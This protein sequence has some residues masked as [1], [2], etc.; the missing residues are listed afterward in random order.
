MPV[1]HQRSI[2]AQVRVALG[3][4]A[5][6]MML[7]SVG[8]LVLA[9]RAA[10]QA[11]DVYLDHLQPMLRLM[12]VSE[13]YSVDITISFRMVRAGRM[14]SEEGLLRLR[15][16]EAKARQSWAAFRAKRAVTPAIQATEAEL[17]RLQVIGN[18]LAVMLPDGRSKALGIFGDNQ[19][20]PEV[21]NCS[22]ILE[23]LRTEE[24]RRAEATIRALELS[25]RRTILSGLLLMLVSLL[26]ALGLGQGFAAHLRQGVDSLVTHL[27]SVADG[28]LEPVP[29]APGGSELVSA[30][31]EL[32]RTVAHLRDLMTELQAQKALERAILDGTHAVI[33]GLDLEGRV[34]RWNRGA[35]LVLGYRAEEVM[36]QA[37]PAL[38]R[39]PEELE[40]LAREVSE[41][42]GRIV[43]PGIEALQA[44][45]SIPGFATECHYRVKDG[46]LVPVLLTISQVRSPDGE[47][48]GTMG[49]ALDLR[50]VHRLK[51]AL[52]DS[53][54][55]YQRLAE[56]LPG[57]VYQTQVWPDG[58]RT[59]PFISP[60]FQALLGVAPLA[61]EQDPDF[62]VRW[63]LP[64]E[65]PEF[66]RRQRE[67][68]ESLGPLTWE[69]RMA[70]ERPGEVKW[71][72]TRSNPTAQP[73]G[74][75]L[76]DGILEDITE[77]KRSEE[78]LR[79]S[80]SR[81]QEASRAKSSFL[82]SMS[83][84]L[85]TPLSAILGYARLM[86]RDPLR[87]EED[88][89]QLDHVLRAG[90]HL[91]ALINDVLSLSKIEA[92]RMEVRLAPFD[93]TALAREV[94]SLFRLTALAKGLA[95]EVETSGLPP[96]V[97]GDA[98]KLRQVLVNLLGNALKFTTQ[99]SV[100][101]RMSWH[102]DV[103][104]A[105]IEDTGPGIPVEEQEH[106]FGAFNQAPLGQSV[107]GTGLGLHISQALVALMLGE[108]GVESA[109]GRGSRFFCTIPLPEPEVPVALASQGR[110]V[111]LA[112]GEAAPHVLVVDDRRENRDILDRLLRLVGFRCSLAE[113]GQ[114]ALEQW[115]EGRPD[116][117]LMDL[118]MPVMDGFQ[119]VA[120]LR[121]A[122]AGSDLRHTPVVAIS[123]SVYDVSR[124]DLL[125]R[126]F[127]A[128]LTKPIDEDELFT[129][130]EELLGLRFE[131]LEGEPLAP[132]PGG[133]QALETQE[134]GWRKRFLEEVATGDLEAAEGLLSELMDPELVKAVRQRLRSYNLDEILQHLR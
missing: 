64:E 5:L 22:Q 73:D 131:R 67:A 124:E 107:G 80:E 21:M 78:A 87:S 91:L 13:A 101:L 115:R 120:R 48:L 65:L 61:W 42:V 8:M 10:R 63:I 3:L 43:A 123:A 31:R 45:A 121:E 99:G 85:R 129:T 60:K 126:G 133:L 44:A 125:R 81:A 68:T 50:D 14:S 54:A 109:P 114:A 93:P 105:V 20:L 37:T 82:A 77:L 16:G 88:R 116:L 51:E 94:E 95:F 76:W 11:S 32:N 57:V 47:L 34:S 104:G 110:V 128:F 90:E 49:V 24:D 62:P 111:R 70:T 41:R 96:Q 46:S 122:E 74:S 27:R 103:L 89:V 79:L 106:L 18:Q 102:R 28:N 117:I 118:R 127:D 33:I 71:I 132:G 26:L 112:G 25:S 39:L 35:E 4:L 84:E 72:R 29:V 98:A 12:E 2:A 130:L 113:H 36:G 75:I 86:A 30:E 9:R 1:L 56:R 17:A 55:R 53:E 92:G 40:A 108:I 15:E 97:E 100:L 66:R 134:S 119:A 38:W 6:L 52:K 83:H 58:R 59:W 23:R 7:G 69:G 19:W